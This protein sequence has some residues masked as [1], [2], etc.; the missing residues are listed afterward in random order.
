MTLTDKQATFAVAVAHLILYANSLG[1]RVTFGEAWRSEHE[2]KRHAL[3]G[4]GIHRS[5]HQD[6]LAVDLNLFRG[7]EWLTRSEDHRPL[8]EWWEAQS[9][10]ALTYVWGGGWGD[11]NH[12]SFLHDGRK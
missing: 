10:D 9:H 1:Y 2:A 3:A 8:G 4:S 12:Y 6:R 5:L 7:G 11:G